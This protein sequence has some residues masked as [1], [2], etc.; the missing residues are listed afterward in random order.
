MAQQQADDEQ[1]R[2]DGADDVRFTEQGFRGRVGFWN[3]M[4]AEYDTYR[5]R[6]PA[7]LLDILTQIARA[8][9]PALVVDLGSGT[10]LS[11]LVWANRA[12]AVIGVEP[13]DDMRQQA[14]RRLASLADA[15]S[16]TFRAGSSTVTGLPEGCAD[17]VTASQALHWME[18]EP[19]FAEIARILRPGGVFAAYDYDW[20]PTVRWEA[21]QAYN[22]FIDRYRALTRDRRLD[23]NRRAWPKEGHLARI[24]ESGRFRFVREIAVASRE[25][26]DAARFIG[27]ALSYGPLQALQAGQMTEDEL[28]VAVFQSTVHQAF[29]GE[30]LPWYLSYRV[31][32]G[33]H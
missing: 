1:Q 20:P 6:P 29:D 17:L 26:G 10:G 2:A 18:P 27:L 30:T 28:G 14:E 24:R 8:P 19:T 22:E 33:I 15:A 4:A 5:P 7:M 9:H 23:A 31:R 12:G 21:E 16:V 3:G 13:N 11:T 25:Q 32:F